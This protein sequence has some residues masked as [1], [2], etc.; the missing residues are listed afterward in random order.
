M[1]SLHIT[2]TCILLLLFLSPPMAV[3]QAQTQNN[4]ILVTHTGNDGPGS[5]RQALE[6]ATSG[7]VVRFEPAAFPPDNPQ[8]IH[9]TEELPSISQG[10]ITIDASDAGVILDGS[11]IN[12]EVNTLVDDIAFSINGEEQFASNFAQGL[13]NWQPEDPSRTDNWLT[14]EPGD[15]HAD[16]GSI[17][18]GNRPPDNL[19][20]YHDLVAGKVWYELY[21]EDSTA[22]YTV[23]PGDQ[24][25]LHYS[26][27]GDPH[28]AMF[29][30]RME[31]VDEAASFNDTTQPQS[32]A[33]QRVAL[34]GVVP[35]GVNRVFPA[36]QPANPHIGAG[37]HLASDGNDIKGLHIQNFNVG[38]IVE[39]HGNIIGSADMEST[40]PV[41][42]ERNCN[43][44]TGFSAGI[45]VIGN[46]N[47]VVGNRISA[48]S[49]EDRKSEWVN[50]VVV[51][52]PSSQTVVAANLVA[53]DSSTDTERMETG[54]YLM[55]GTQASQVGPNNFISGASVFGISVVGSD[56][57][58][59]G[60]EIIASGNCG[61]Y[62][63][64]SSHAQMTGNWVGIT[65][66]GQVDG[67]QFGICLHSAYYT[68][69]GPGN[70]VAHNAMHGIDIGDCT[71]TTISGNSIYQNGKIGIENWTP[72][73]DQLPPPEIVTV[74]YTTLTV[75]GNSA[76]GS[77]VELYFDTA[78]QGEQFA[79]ACTANTRGRFH[80]TI[81]R[82]NFQLEKNLTA[83]AS[84]ADNST[85]VFSAPYYVRTPEVTSL[86]GITGPLSISTDPEVVGISLGIAI[87]LFIASNLLANMSTEWLP[88]ATRRLFQRQVPMGK[89]RT[90]TIRTAGKPVIHLVT[91]L[92]I[93]TSTALAQSMLEDH[94]LFSVPFLKLF[95]L[96]LVVTVILSLAEVGSAWLVRKAWKE[97]CRFKPEIEFRSI[98]FVMLSVLISRLL[99]FSPGIVVGLVG[100]VL[101]LPE[102]AQERDGISSLSVLSG[103]FLLS[104]AC[105]G[106]SAVFTRTQPALEILL[107]TV[108][109]F[110]V[111]SVFFSLLPYAESAGASI[112]QWNRKIWWLLGITVSAVFVHMIFMPAFTDVGAFR[113]NDY[114]TLYIILG[115][116]ILLTGA[117][118]LIRKWGNHRQRVS[119]PTDTARDQAEPG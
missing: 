43:D 1:K 47:W 77:Q 37:I 95:L 35:D 15:G 109:F 81:P 113:Y 55:Q 71:L 38:V 58:I 93:L 17:R 54:I 46:E 23:E 73:G 19:I 4:V 48:L 106:L 34:S 68:T 6:Q 87:F 76:P 79:A 101:L 9:L 74:S 33:W 63:Y 7:S 26:Y 44:I 59:I 118:W 115:S 78:D 111:Q 102:L 97:P 110:G 92:A 52:P 31:G 25:E 3:L 84:G 14:W 20:L 8:V 88:D 22:W 56:D 85:S 75:L 96:L 104:M 89:K 57:A 18:F 119:P 5:L 66:Q 2:V 12:V 10:L 67:N 65:R 70:H 99:H 94:A 86:T 21:A 39:G 100:S 114:I 117:L 16:S 41:V 24:L 83:I 103:I 107:L 108:F 27:K 82:D 11:G 30:Y 91:W 62:A 29:A 69:I 40:Y 28:I 105:W 13:D 42:C 32:G 36:L 80:C 45:L 64:E 53:Y 90:T 60:N 51:A 72:Q 61:I 98:L 116:L 50:A 49:P 112:Y